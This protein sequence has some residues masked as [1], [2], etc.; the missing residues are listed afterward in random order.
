[1][2]PG[3]TPKKE[4]KENI[5]YDSSVPYNKASQRKIQDIGG[6]VPNLARYT[7]IVTHSKKLMKRKEKKNLT[8]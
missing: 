5:W 6:S 1:L 7:S 4:R 8:E 3:G 2:P